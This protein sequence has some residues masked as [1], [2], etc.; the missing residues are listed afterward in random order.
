[1]A[2]MLI[3]EVAKQSGL[4]VRT[5]R[6]WEQVGL[7][8]PTRTRARQRAYGP[9]QLIRIGTIQTLKKAGFTL[10]AIAGML[11]IKQLDTG[12]I[13]AAQIAMLEAQQVSIQKALRSLKMLQDR[14]LDDTALSPADLSNLI[15]IGGF[16]VSDEDQ[17]KAWQKTYDQFYTE[18]EQQRWIEAKQAMAP[19]VIAD[20]ERR[21]PLVIDRVEGLIANG[22]PHDCKEAGEC[23]AEWRALTN[24]LL[25]GHPDL[26]Q[27]AG[28]LYDQMDQWPADGAEPPFSSAVWQYIK[29]A[30]THFPEGG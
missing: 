17:K 6:H 4:S 13:L 20:A 25:E 22:D 3:G 2:M 30:Y 21:W 19:D 26:V 29:Q 27:S 15:R 7:L 24:Q 11:A 28:L 16:A 14:G 23:V 1:M 18:E 5:L 9:D 8:S 12:Q 10:S